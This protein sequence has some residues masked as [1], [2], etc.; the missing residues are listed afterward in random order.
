M[1]PVFSAA[2]DVQVDRRHPARPVRYMSLL[3]CDIPAMPCAGNRPCDPCGNLRVT[4]A[5]RWTACFRTWSG[6]CRARRGMTPGR[7]WLSCA[8]SGALSASDATDL[9]HDDNTSVPHRETAR[10][11]CHPRHAQGVTT[12]RTP[13]F[14][15]GLLQ[16]SPP[17]VAAQAMEQIS[18]DPGNPQGIPRHAPCACADFSGTMRP[19]NA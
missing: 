17:Q 18:L 5:I 12:C 1:S 8:R 7:K 14:C 9:R 13:P 10:Q 15:N 11:P 3:R 19:R 16:G 2:P 4:G 6:S